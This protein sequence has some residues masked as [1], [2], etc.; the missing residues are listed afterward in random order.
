[1]F[2]PS[3]PTGW[4]E[5]Q[6]HSSW[7]PWIECAAKII[8]GKV[9]IICLIVTS[10]MPPQNVF[11]AF[12]TVAGASLIKLLSTARF[13]HTGTKLNLSFAAWLRIFFQF[14]F[15]KHEAAACPGQHKQGSTG[16]LKLLVLLIEKS[17]KLLMKEMS[18]KSIFTLCT[19]VF[20]NVT[21][22]L[23]DD[24]FM[25]VGRVLFL[26]SFMDLK[27]LFQGTLCERW[28]PC[29]SAVFVCFLSPVLPS[30]QSE[31]ANQH[32]RLLPVM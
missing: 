31:L 21:P 18:E 20:C 19:L 4:T 17:L 27:D 9:L 25:C 28:A 14:V 22:D 26:N 29:H 7:T 10:L 15:V 1:M 12:L 6:T 30:V 23:K 3:W 16:K 11:K 32:S 24:L 8:N 13:L 5:N 2:Q